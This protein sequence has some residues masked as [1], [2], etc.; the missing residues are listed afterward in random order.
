MGDWNSK[1]DDKACGIK[2]D[3]HIDEKF[4]DEY[5]IL[6]ESGLKLYLLSIMKYVGLDLQETMSF[7]VQF[8]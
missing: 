2:L 8:R 5:A 4:K 3:I 7:H 6:L 1:N